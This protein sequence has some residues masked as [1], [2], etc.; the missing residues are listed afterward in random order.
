[1]GKQRHRHLWVVVL[2][3][4]LCLVPR[5][6][7]AQPT[8]QSIYQDVK[9]IIEE[10]VTKEVAEAV[11]PNLACYSKDGL[12]RY[13]PR[14]LQLVFERNLGLLE[15]T[16]REETI[17]FLGNYTLASLNRGKPVP[18]AEF[19]PIS[20]KEYCRDGRDCECGEKIR[21]LRGPVPFIR[22]DKRRRG[23]TYPLDACRSPAAEATSGG[24][25]SGGI[26]SGGVK[27]TLHCELVAAMVDAAKAKK[28]SALEH[29]SRAIAVA[30][31]MRAGFPADTPPA[32]S[33]RIIDEIVRGVQDQLTEGAYS[34]RS[35]LSPL[36]K[37]SAKR[38]E[39]LLEVDL[40]KLISKAPRRATKHTLAVVIALKLMRGDSL[41]IA[42]YAGGL[43]KSRL[44]AREAL[45]RLREDS[46]PQK[47]GESLSTGVV[48]ALLERGTV[49]PRGKAT[50]SLAR[51]DGRLELRVDLVPD[52]EAPKSDSLYA[53]GEGLSALE[54][55]LLGERAAE[56]L[57][58]R[59]DDLGKPE[60]IPNI[61]VAL[62]RVTGDVVAVVR[63]WE[64][65][66]KEQGGAVDPKRMLE[67]IRDRCGDGTVSGTT[68]TGEPTTKL[69]L[70]ALV[71]QAL[72]VFD[73]TGQLKP[74]IDAALDGDL[75]EVASTA[76]RAVFSPALANRLCCEVDDEDACLQRVDAYANL[77]TSFV[78]YATL[79]EGDDNAEMAARTAFKR[80]A[81][82]VVTNLGSRNGYDRKDYWTRVIIPTASL[83]A[84]LS[85]SY[86]NQGSDGF[87]YLATIDFLTLP[88]ILRDRDT[89][90]M[91]L[92]VSLVDLLAPFGEIAFR[93]IDTR[94]QDNGMVFANF[95]RP[96]VELAFG[97]PTL[98][99]KLML[100]GGGS[101]RPVIA[102]PKSDKTDFDRQYLFFGTPERGDGFDE[103]GLLSALEFGIGVKYVP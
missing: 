86:Y 60:S 29:M 17:E 83:R 37:V 33:K 103:E 41:D 79:K 78:S 94:Y 49:I 93:D 50:V 43:E 11:A 55:L 67:A 23:W 32:D 48:R 88:I 69:D 74:L 30:A 100:V 80:A 58:A 59:L 38:L 81:F 12:L 31:Y 16:L 66:L 4:M 25:K 9:E 18:V 10:L 7:S 46:L 90:R 34:E 85:P 35:K 20:P 14:T 101:L 21:E 53:V 96:N 15:D 45:E 77:A 102:K 99:T 42:L 98:S 76:V 2:A 68:A 61:A 52:P 65:V 72:L 51:H 91:E 36:E 3:L 6:A 5:A 57:E 27:N 26:Q 71:K 62:I 75:R 95:L 44:D 54:L 39:E 82:D 63:S 70:C 19:M 89:V 28:E 56:K 1:M 13:F 92:Q 73:P 64:R 97:L 87:R 24:V 8:S 84:S 40:E 22:Y 47:S